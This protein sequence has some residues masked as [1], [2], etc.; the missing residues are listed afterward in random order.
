MC[1]SHTWYTNRQQYQCNQ[2]KQ[3]SANLISSLLSRSM[4][5]QTPFINLLWK[6]IY[7]TGPSLTFKP[8]TFIPWVV[9]SSITI[10]ATSFHLPKFFS[11]PSS[12]RKEQFKWVLFLYSL[13]FVLHLKSPTSQTPLFRS[14]Q[15][16][17]LFALS[18]CFHLRYLHLSS[19][20]IFTSF[21]TSVI[22][23]C[24][25]L[26]ILLCHHSRF[27]WS[28]FLSFHIFHFSHPHMAS[29]TWSASVVTDVM[30][31]CTNHKPPHSQPYFKSVISTFASTEPVVFMQG[32]R[33]I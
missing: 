12:R 8:I 33:G 28:S 2:W 4:T 24:H 27:Y 16:D 32:F 10:K 15:W 5:R 13:F 14:I 6:N 20:V 31:I 19:T 21:I 9:L 25:P 17:I 3:K 7:F 30:F 23:I 11:S 1:V 29:T 18:H 26:E 22:L